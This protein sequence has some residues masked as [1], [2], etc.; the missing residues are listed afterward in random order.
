MEA[1][2]IPPR[3]PPVAAPLAI[4]PWVQDEDFEL[5][6]SQSPQ[7]HWLAEDSGGRPYLGL[8]VGGSLAK[9]VFFDSVDRPAPPKVL[10]FFMQSQ[11]YGTTG[12]R[13]CDLEVHNEGIGG[14]LHFV[15]FETSSMERV[16]QMV[17]ENNLHEGLTQ[18]YATGGGAHKYQAVF[19]QELGLSFVTKDELGTV[20]RGI[21]FL[22]HH[23]HDEG[24]KIE[25]EGARPSSPELTRTP[26]HSEQLFPFLLCKSAV[27]S[28][29]CMWSPPQ[30]S[31][32]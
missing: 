32:G 7:A 26:S 8:D 20:I 16:I 28:A 30:C 22:A 3:T 21:T 4:H 1:E 14:T 17:K 23:L 18:V 31:S 11:T 24:Q 10:Q 13:H 29:S 6:Q 5:A 19:E 27:A 25:P 2:E 12:K 15:Q 9:L